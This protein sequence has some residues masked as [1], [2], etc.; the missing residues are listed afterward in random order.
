MVINL[1]LPCGRFFFWDFLQFH[2]D[3]ASILDTVYH[4]ISSIHSLQTLSDKRGSG[5]SRMIK[6]M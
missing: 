3:N 5:M 2:W 6:V 1:C 4:S